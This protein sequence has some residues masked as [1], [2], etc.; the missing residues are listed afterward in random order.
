VQAGVPH[1]QIAKLMGHTSTAMITR[2]YGRMP[3][4]DLQRLLDAR[5]GLACVTPAVAAE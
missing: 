5:L 1:D 2:V 3:P 4:D